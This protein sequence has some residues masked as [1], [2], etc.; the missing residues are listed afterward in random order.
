MV[1]HQLQLDE[2]RCKH[3]YAK[4]RSRDSHQLG[5]S[6]GTSTEPKAKVEGQTKKKRGNGIGHSKA[7]REQKVNVCQRDDTKVDNDQQAHLE[8]ALES[9]FFRKRRPRQLDPHKQKVESEEESHS[10]DQLH[11]HDLR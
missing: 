1:D 5:H 7:R 11:H 8:V 9:L 2:G 4:Q 10:V 6:S 3:H